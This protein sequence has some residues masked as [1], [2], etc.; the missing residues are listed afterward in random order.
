MVGITVAHNGGD[1]IAVTGNSLGNGVAPSEVYANGG[2]PID[3]NDDG[4]TLNDPGDVDSGPNTLLNYP[5]VTT[6]VGNTITGTACANCEVD[7]YFAYASTQLS[8][9]SVKYVGSAN[10]NG[11]GLFSAVLPAS[12]MNHGVSYAL[13]AT[14]FPGAINSSEISPWWGAWMP[15]LRR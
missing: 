5:V 14:Q 9:G 15:S 8:G 13:Q 4:P 3:L 6:R 2:I 12:I 11:A 1:G 10:A 7:I